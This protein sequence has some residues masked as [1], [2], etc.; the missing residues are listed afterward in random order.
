MIQLY[1]QRHAHTET[2]GRGQDD[3]D[4]ALDAKGYRQLEALKA[5]YTDHFSGRSIEVFCSTAK[6]TQETLKAL[7]KT[8]ETKNEHF[9][10]ALYLPRLIELQQFVWSQQVAESPVL[11][12]GH[13]NA[14]SD[15]A[16]YYL[17]DSIMLPTGGLIGLQF[18]GIDD[19]ASTSKGL[20]TEI[21]RF[22]P[23]K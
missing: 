2:V 7:S 22:F 12:V 13:N 23:K 21:V 9:H 14:L 4:R 5:F 16:S 6:R 20:A 19:L 8:I 3:F 10:H 11:F 1:L 15:L 18:D 17:D